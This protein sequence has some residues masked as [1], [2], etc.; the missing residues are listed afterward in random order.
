MIDLDENLNFVH[1]LIEIKRNKRDINN[2]R[3]FYGIS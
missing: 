2:F 3:K 1:Y